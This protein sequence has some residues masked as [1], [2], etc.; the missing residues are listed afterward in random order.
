VVLRDLLLALPSRIEG[1][2]TVALA[3]HGNRLQHAAGVWVIEDLAQVGGVA[4]RIALPAFRHRAF[5]RN[6]Q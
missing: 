4:W 6:F 1:W 2:F 3:A 5:L